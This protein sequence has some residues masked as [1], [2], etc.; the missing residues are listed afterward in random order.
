[1]RELVRNYLISL[2]LMLTTATFVLK[3]SSIPI[4]HSALAAVSGDKTIILQG[5]GAVSRKGY[6]F[7]QKKEGTD[8]MD[9]VAL[10]AQQDSCKRDSCIRYQFFRKDGSAGLAK[11]GIPKGLSRA[12]F[13]LADLVGHP[14]PATMDDDG[15]YSAVV[16]VYYLGSDGQEYSILFNGF[17]RLNILSKGYDPVGCSDPAIAWHLK[18]IDSCEAQFTTAGRAVVCG[19]GCEP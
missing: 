8:L 3:C 14:G 13:T 18:V 16:Q 6:L 4:D 9:P 19:K 17:V 7:F 1:M 12:E 10:I 2:F 11:G 5:G 15:E